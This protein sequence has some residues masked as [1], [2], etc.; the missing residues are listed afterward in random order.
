MILKDAVEKIGWNAKSRK[1]IL[2]IGD[3]PPHKKD[4]PLAI[5]VIKK[6]K[7]E[8]GGVVSVIDVR[9]PEYMTDNIHETSNLEPVSPESVIYQDDH[10][11]VMDE[12][13]IFAEVGGG[14]CARLIDEEKVVKHMLLLIF[15]SRW[16]MYLDEFMKNL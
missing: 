15:G 5:E 10:L 9:E 8:M 12:F 4:I 13:R 11:A 3:A 7:G 16:E 6:F 1:F 14:E 2:L